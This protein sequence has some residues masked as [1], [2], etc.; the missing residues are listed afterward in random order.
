MAMRSK[1]MNKSHKANRLYQKRHTCYQITTRIKQ[2]INAAAVLKRGFRIFSLFDL[3]PFKAVIRFANTIP[4][5]MKMT[6]LQTV[7]ISLKFKATE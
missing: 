1:L 4:S 7:P 3:N 6:K 5:T 2:E